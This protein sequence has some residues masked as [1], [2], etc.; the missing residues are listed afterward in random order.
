MGLS[1]EVLERSTY[2]QGDFVAFPQPEIRAFLL[3]QPEFIL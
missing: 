3:W 1:Q 2:Q